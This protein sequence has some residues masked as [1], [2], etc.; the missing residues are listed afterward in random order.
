MK[1][2]KIIG[3]MLLAGLGWMEVGLIVIGLEL[4]AFWFGWVALVAGT[5]L[6]ALA[7]DKALDPP[8]RW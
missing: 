1:N 3:L 5:S 8:K 7:V 4:P 2:W 6:I